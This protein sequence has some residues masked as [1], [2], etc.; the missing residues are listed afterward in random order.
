MRL[1]APDHANGG[2]HHETARIACAIVAGN[3]WDGYFTET[4]GGERV[5]ADKNELL[6]KSDYYFHVPPSNRSKYSPSII[7][8]WDLADLFLQ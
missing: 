6:T 1:Q 4:P 8:R 5:S 7:V 2:I 3:R